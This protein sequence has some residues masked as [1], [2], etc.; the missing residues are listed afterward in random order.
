MSR[1]WVRLALEAGAACTHREEERTLCADCA[2]RAIDL[3]VDVIARGRVAHASPGE[4]TMEEERISRIEGAIAALSAQV[5]PEDSRDA[6]LRILRAEWPAVVEELRGLRRDVAS[7]A[8]RVREL[9][10]QLDGARRCLRGVGAL[11][12]TIGGDK[13]QAIAVFGKAFGE[14]DAGGK[15]EVVCATSGGPRR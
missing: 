10:R 14:A 13:A 11:A 3:A 5:V 2:A 6:A 7:Q 1:P 9:V 8:A 12:E 15:R 4:G